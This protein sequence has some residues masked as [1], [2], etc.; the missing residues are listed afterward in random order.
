MVVIALDNV[1]YFLQHLASIY[2]RHLTAYCL[3]CNPFSELQEFSLGVHT[4]Y[5]SYEAQ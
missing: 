1:C 5:T 2:L 4:F 3:K